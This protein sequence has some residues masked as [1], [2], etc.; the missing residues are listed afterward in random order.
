MYKHVAFEETAKSRQ[1][2]IIANA[3]V[4]QNY[5]NMHMLDLNAFAEQV[6]EFSYSYY[7][8][9]FDFG[10]IVDRIAKGDL[11]AA[12]QYD[13]ALADYLNALD[14]TLSRSIDFMATLFYKFAN[15][16]DM[17][18]FYTAG[19]STG[20]TIIG[21]TNYQSTKPI[22]IPSIIN[23]AT[24][25]AIGNSAFANSLLTQI[26]I[27]AS[28]TSIG[29]A[30][31]YGCTGLTG[32]TIP[33]GVTYIDREAFAY[34][35]SLASITVSSGNSVYKSDGNCLIETATNTLIAGC[36]N[37]V[38]PNY[39]S[40]IGEYAFRGCTGLTNINIPVSVTNIELTA[41]Y[42]TNLNIVK[43]DMMNGAGGN[44]YVVVAYG[45]TMPSATAPTREGYTFNGYY[46]GNTK[47][48]NADMTYA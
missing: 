40:T 12:I 26:S 27:P 13:G 8:A 11:W 42:G 23:G 32:I 7:G 2:Q 34:C 47:Y 1:D 24:V 18:G 38:I 43:L 17:M 48:Y 22:T 19:N 25:T 33:A 44:S 31:F 3:N 37:S 36:K 21:I 10:M 45:S 14:I 35:S 5:N 46:F 30:A 39:V 28:V 20:L 29:Y 4:D 15:D 9:I 16:V 41:F 6:A